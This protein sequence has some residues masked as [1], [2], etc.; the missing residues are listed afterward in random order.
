MQLPTA[1]REFRVGAIFLAAAFALT[2]AY[3]P[4]GRGAAQNDIYDFVGVA[5]S[6]AIV[7]GVRLNRPDYP[8]PWLL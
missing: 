7:L 1:V 5:S 4:I 3:F 8:L 6:F 2:I